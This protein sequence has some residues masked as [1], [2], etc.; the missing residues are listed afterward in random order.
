M[1]RGGARGWSLG[2][3]A[4]QGLGYELWTRWARA[5]GRGNG[6]KLTDT[7]GRGAVGLMRWG[8]EGQGVA[9]EG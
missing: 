8:A 1:Q 6:A 3:R 4:R 9:L 7:E 5:W 2:G